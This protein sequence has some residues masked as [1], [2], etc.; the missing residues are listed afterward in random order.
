MK[1]G[2]KL[3]KGYVV[4]AMHDSK[5]ADVFLS[6]SKWFS[7]K[8]RE[9]FWYD[10]NIL[11]KGLPRE[12]VLLESKV[13]YHNIICK[14]FHVSVDTHFVLY[15]PTFRNNGQADCYDIDFHRL[16]RT[17]DAKYGVKHKV[18]LRLHPNIRQKI[19]SI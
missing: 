3:S 7:K 19:L 14:Y 5:M 11:E 12:D 13:N 15:A 9:D 10:G 2:K 8:I 18:I 17:L 6:D 1:S 4:S 16:V